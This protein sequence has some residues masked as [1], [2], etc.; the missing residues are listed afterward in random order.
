M[1]ASTTVYG[2]VRVLVTLLLHV[3]PYFVPNE[4]LTGWLL[5]L[6]FIV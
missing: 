2:L 3:M 6:N 5:G 1:V 4:L